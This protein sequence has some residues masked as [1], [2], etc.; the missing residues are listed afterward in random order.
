MNDSDSDDNDVSGQPPNVETK[1]K[2]ANV[3]DNKTK[4]VVYGQVFLVVVAWTTTAGRLIGEQFWNQRLNQ[5]KMQ[6]VIEDQEYP[7]A[8]RYAIEH[9]SLSYYKERYIVFFP[10]I[11]GACIWW[12]FYFLQLIPSI[13]KKYKRFHRILGRLLMVAALCQCISGIGL[14]YL[15]KS[16][17]VAI[18]SYLM[19]ISVIYCV[20]NAWYYA[21]LKDIARHKYWAMRLVGYLQT[22]SLNL[23]VLGLLAVWYYTE[24]LGLYPPFDPDDGETF[25]KIFEDSMIL[26]YAGAVLVTEWYLAGYYGWTETPPPPKQE[27]V[28]KAVVYR[29]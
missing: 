18:V 22:T 26:A 24:F 17:T 12:G 9:F 15:G 16:S 14:A 28:T 3:W 13:R 7:K 29:V 10:H 2:N 6:D 8:L 11:I 21:I 27:D 23:V 25:V 4:F 1:N 19:A 20:Y 5:E